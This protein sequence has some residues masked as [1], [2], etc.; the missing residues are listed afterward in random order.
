M[1]N[2]RK[3]WFALLIAL[4]VFLCSI[5]AGA[6]VDRNGGS[7]EVQ[8]VYFTSTL[9]GS[10]LHGRLYIPSTAT[11]DNPAPSVIFIQGND[12]ESEKYSMFSVEFARRGYVV[13]NVDLRGQGKS[14]GNT[15]FNDMA[16][17]L[18]DALGAD[19][20]GAY[21]RSLPFVDSSKIVVGGHSMGGIASIRTVHNNPDWYTSLLLLGCTA[22]DCGVSSDNTN[23]GP[24]AFDKSAAK[25]MESEDKMLPFAEDEDNVNILI[26]TGRDDG[27]AVNHNGVARF[28]GLESADDFV[29]GKVYGS[30]EE[31]NVR[32]NYQAQCVHNWEYMSTKVL[33]TCIDFVQNSV[34]APNPI[35]AGSQVWM[36]RYVA[37]TIALIA[38]IGM[39]LPLGT[40]I[41]STGFFA[42]LATAEPAYKGNRGKKWWLFAVI[43]AL[44][45][46]ALY[47]YGCN[48]ATW[49]NSSWFNIVRI[50]CTL[51]WTIFVAIATLI[52]IAIGV[53]LTKKEERASLANLGLVYESGTFV[54]ILKSLLLAV[55]LILSIYSVL[56]V[57]YRWSLVDVRIWNTSFRELNSVR[58]VRVLKYFV[59]FAVCYI[60]AAVNLYGFVRPKNG[61]LSLFKEILVNVLIQAPWY[62]I[63]CIW[64]GTNGLIRGGGL[65]YFAGSMYAFFW[66]VPCIMA[67]IS[68]ISTYFNRKTGHVY[69]GAFVSAFLVAW[70]LVGGLSRMV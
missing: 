39:M 33:N 10:L 9:D 3:A 22:A 65:P 41:L 26:V 57:T 30:Y 25:Q 36:W 66:C 16:T 5:T 21:V 47:F 18:Y 68:V 53:A 29:S 55:I 2:S 12:G 7:T 8:D 52:I 40:I 4:A 62:F 27:D 15:G 23:L 35:D 37:T 20:A 60:I 1:K 50:N 24:K 6:Y 61:E 45:P 28:C 48:H 51:S 32:I 17:G 63:W 54:K 13:F 58:M 70:T 34:P 14:V 64:L 67:I 59:P 43:S 31:N 44:L 46:P 42:D 11:K 19:E 69:V 56:A 49:L 38:L